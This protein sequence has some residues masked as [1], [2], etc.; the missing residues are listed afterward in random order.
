MHTLHIMC[1]SHLQV[2]ANPPDW[3]GYPEPSPPPPQPATEEGEAPPVT[4]HWDKRLTS[5]QKLIMIKCFKEEK[6]D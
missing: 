3:D 4:G 5:F 1:S 6:V 2:H